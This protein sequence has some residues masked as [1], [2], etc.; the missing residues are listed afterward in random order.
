MAWGCLA[1]ITH[2]CWTI[3]EAWDGNVEMWCL[4]SW[5]V[6]TRALIVHF[7]Y[8]FSAGWSSEQ[9]ALATAS[10]ILPDWISCV[11]SAFFSVLLLVER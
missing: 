7:H 4:A 11:E 5:V 8:H 10:T 3:I 9:E 2:R 1:H 6:L